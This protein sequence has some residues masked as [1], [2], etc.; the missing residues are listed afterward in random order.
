MSFEDLDDEDWVD[1]SWLGEVKS[2]IV[3]GMVLDPDVT[4]RWA[5]LLEFKKNGS[6]AVGNGFFV[7]IPDTTTHHII[8]TAAHNL[9]TREGV[10]TADLTAVYETNPPDPSNPPGTRITQIVPEE[11]IYICEGY[12]KTGRPED[13]YGFIR[14]KRNATEKT[15]GFGFSIKLAY[16]D[17]FKDKIYVSGFEP[18]NRAFNIANGACME[19]YTKIVVYEAKTQQG[20]SGS[21]VWIDYK[22]SQVAIAIHNTGSS[23]NGSSGARLTPDV[24][25][26]AFN[27]IQPSVMKKGIQ[28][29]AYAPPK[30]KALPKLPDKGLFLSFE[31]GMGFGRVR[32]GSGTKFD[33]MPGQSI[34]LKGGVYINEFCLATMDGKW[35]TFDCSGPR[36]SKIK[37]EIDDGCHFK[38]DKKKIVVEQKG[39]SYELRVENSYIK[40]YDE[41]SESS[42]VSFQTYPSPDSAR[43][44]KFEFQ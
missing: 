24:F 31:S 28:I 33:L 18:G 4:K 41:N 30:S 6:P 34:H 3:P 43:F 20:I 7:G 12:T 42:E 38:I 23:G 19:C 32:L 10:R 15:F 36:V 13:D 27:W 29:R 26:R 2:E 11:D 21:A 22:N 16:E 5:V 40:E 39:R 17:Y 14:I 1:P 37:Q 8:F 9:T 35:V 25:R 44:N